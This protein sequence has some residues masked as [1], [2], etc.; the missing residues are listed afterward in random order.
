MYVGQ[1]QVTANFI[2]AAATADGDGISLL[3]FAGRPP[4]SVSATAWYFQVRPAREGGCRREALLV[5][6]RAVGAKRLLPIPSCTEQNLRT[7]CH[8]DNE[9]LSLTGKM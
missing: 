2:H 8:I 7:P 3:F 9:L 6:Q 1:A 5:S 4:G